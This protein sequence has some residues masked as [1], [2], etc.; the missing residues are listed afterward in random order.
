LG[1]IQEGTNMLTETMN[2]VK[3]FTAPDEV[4][5]FRNGRVEL[6]HFGDHVIAKAIL[7]PGWRWSKDVK[8]ISKTEWCEVSHFQYVISGHLHFVTSDKQ[9]F[10]F[11]EG[12]VLR[13]GGGHDAWVVGHEPF[14]AVD[15]T[16]M[17]DYAQK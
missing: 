8:P 1:S 15:W 9:E 16:G 2:Q 12:D 3:R 4:R 17:A 11:K 13:V 5:G 6:L 10:D 7:L 14:V